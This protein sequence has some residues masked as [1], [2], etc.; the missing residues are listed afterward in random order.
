MEILWKIDLTL[1]IFLVISVFAYIGF[2]DSRFE[3]VSFW[4]SVVLFLLLV[5]SIAT[6]L[7]LKIW[8]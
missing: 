7:L 8:G 4:C 2:L 6:Q 5:T 3:D 1:T